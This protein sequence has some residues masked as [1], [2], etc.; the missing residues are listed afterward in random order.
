MNISTVPSPCL[1]VLPPVRRSHKLTILAAEV[2]IATDPAILNHPEHQARCYA[3]G[4]K[5]ELVK[6]HGV[7]RVILHTKEDTVERVLEV[8]NGIGVDSVFDGARFFLRSHS[9]Y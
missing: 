2:I 1:H 6:G 9:A 4:A 7:D 3:I 8:T 5:A